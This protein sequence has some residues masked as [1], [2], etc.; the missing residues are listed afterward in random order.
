MRHNHN[1]RAAQNKAKDTLERK[2]EK[3]FPDIL[4]GVQVYVKN[5]HFV[6]PW[7]QQIICAAVR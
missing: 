7:H 3:R 1:V 5:S 2:R 6:A 4:T